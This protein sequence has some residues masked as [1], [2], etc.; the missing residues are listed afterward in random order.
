MVLRQLGK[1][2]YTSGYS[3]ILNSFVDEKEKKKSIAE[4]LEKAKEAVSVDVKDGIS[5]SMIMS[6][7][8]H[9][10]LSL[11]VILGNAYLAMFFSVSADP[12]MLQQASSAYTQAVHVTALI[13][14]T[15]S[16]FN[17]SYRRRTLLL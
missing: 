12:K 11:S 7:I 4:S 14:C 3:S 10:S 1:G 13:L 6:L 2:Q 8:S 15:S 16:L 5:W 17:I 9:L